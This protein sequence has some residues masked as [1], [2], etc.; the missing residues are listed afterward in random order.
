MS[1]CSANIYTRFEDVEKDVSDIV[2]F[3]SNALSN[4]SNNDSDTDSEY[5]D[6]NDYEPS[7][8][9]RQRTQQLSLCNTYKIVKQL[10]MNIEGITIY[11]Y[12]EH[13]NWHMCHIINATDDNAICIEFLTIAGKEYTEGILNGLPMRFHAS[14]VSILDEIAINTKPK[15]HCVRI[16][17]KSKSPTTNSETKITGFSNLNRLNLEIFNMEDTHIERFIQYVKG[18]FNI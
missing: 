14:P 18:E 5:D 1:T 11:I 15:S 17:C 4:Y 6:Y 12:Q 8:I 2:T 3:F 10:F 7:D 16:I 13:D 9:V